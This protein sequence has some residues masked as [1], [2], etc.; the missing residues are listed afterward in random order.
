[1]YN[2]ESTVYLKNLMD[3]PVTNEKLQIALSKYPLYE[4]KSKE[5]YIP[6]FIPTREELNKAILNKYK[7]REIGHETVGRFLDE[8][9]IAMDEIMPYYNQ[10]LFSA[11]QDFNIIFNVDYQRTI[12]T[13]K[14]GKSSSKTTGK[15]ET[16]TIIEDNATNHTTASDTQNTKNNV[17]ESGKKVHSE[18]PQSELSITA[19]NIDG[20][21][22]ADDVEW[23][24]NGT[25]SSGETSGVN[26]A[27]SETTSHG[28]NSTSGNNE[29]N[30][31][32]ET[33]ET[34]NTIETTKGNFGVVSAQDLVLKYRET[35][36]NIKK[37][38][39]EDKRLKELFMT[40]Y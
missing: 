14:G 5:E 18:T 36:L 28:K 32:G 11:D 26:T 15:D 25:E 3:N 20:V 12:N 30:A 29:V 34:E 40:V 35:I 16:E 19:D 39:I 24:K 9:E 17:T 13:D 37:M 21:S 23:N 8:L 27:D 7:Y 4:K 1:M 6:V 2:A 10:L 33:E 31:S 22:Y 38:I